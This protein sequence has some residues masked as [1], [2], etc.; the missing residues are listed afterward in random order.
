M[1]ME[2]GQFLGG[3]RRPVL[4][5]LLAILAA[6]LIE[7]SPSV[8][9]DSGGPI[10]VTGFNVLTASWGTATTSVSVAPGSQYVPLTVT[11]QYFYANT[12]SAIQMTLTMPPGFTD[13]NGAPLAVAFVSGTV[14]SGSTVT[15]TFYLN[16]ASSTA[17]GTYFF[18]LAVNWA[19]Q[20]STPQQ[21]VALVQHTYATVYL[22][23]KAMLN[24]QASQSS[25]IPGQ[26]NGIQFVLSNTGSGSAN[27]IATTAAATSATVSVLNPFPFVASLAPNSSVES[28]LK[29]FVPSSAS[30]SAV[31]ITFTSTYT[32][33]NGNAA[34]LSQTVGLY[35]VSTAAIPAANSLSVGATSSSVVAGS[36]SRVA[37]SIKNDGQQQ[38][39]AP[40]VTLTASSPLVVTANSTVTMPGFVLSPGGTLLYSAEVTA[41]AG[42]TGG[43][44]TGTIAIA[45][46]DQSGDSFSQ[47]VPVTFQVTV[48]VTQVTAS[49]VVSQIGIGRIS[50]VSF[51]ISNSGTYPVY[52]PSVAL[53]V[54]SG[55]AVTSNSTVSMTGL[56]LAPGQSVRYTAGV[57]TGPKT[58]EGAY[59]ATLTVGYVD[60][61]GNSH[62][63]TFNVG[64]VA[65]G[66]IQLVVQNQK[67]SINGTT[68]SMTGTLLNEGLAN[69]YYTQVTGTLTAG[70]TQLAAA[71]SYVGEVDSNTPLPVSL[72]MTIPSS[73]LASLNG[74]GTFTLTA[75]YQND[76]GQALQFKSTEKVQLSGGSSTGASPATP[77]SGQTVST[78]TLDVVR[79]GALGLIA[80]AALAT[81][82]YLRRGRSKRKAGSKS[83][84]Y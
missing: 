71:S 3:E 50:T 81:A 37:F 48:P 29:V 28:T 24:F 52:S 40:T 5:L 35:S 47:T 23:G 49:S 12:A 76:F 53:A 18:P 60:Q 4:F 38:A 45:F 19:A 2:V 16:I 30:G 72:S 20:I 43:F 26:V 55:L 9:A 63:S 78:Q 36:T 32:D 66:E 75:D 7:W 62:S 41:G 83:D 84:V 56:V 67:V 46:T 69:A 31:G 77:S 17:T 8:A 58:A 1:R 34:Q 21:S 80:I 61:F 70:T 42:V 14:T 22:K 68:V 51:M 11:L 15:A 59:P 74:T 33:S 82:L 73:D 6:S 10:E 39:Y 27:Q 79:Y 25:L 13:A 64:L 65:V 57:T 44:Y 54:P